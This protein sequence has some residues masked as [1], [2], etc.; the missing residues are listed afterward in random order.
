MGELEFLVI[1]NPSTPGTKVA[2]LVV[3]HADGMVEANLD[4]NGFGASDEDTDKTTYYT[5]SAGGVGGLP[6]A[7][8][9][10]LIRRRRR[11]AA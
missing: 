9:V 8:V 2:K 3:Q 5:C 4:G 10:L 7:L 1:M 11:R 6:I